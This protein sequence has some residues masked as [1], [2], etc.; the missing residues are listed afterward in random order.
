MIG[1]SFET[2]PLV[3][4]MRDGG[5]VYCDEFTGTLPKHRGPWTEEKYA[6][7]YG[8]V[9]VA[10][11]NVCTGRHCAGRAAAHW[12]RNGVGVYHR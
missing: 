1:R 8:T 4:L 9:R 12:H 3:Q 10:P 6:F 5:T 11:A 2:P 7:A